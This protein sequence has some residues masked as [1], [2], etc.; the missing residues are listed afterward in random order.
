MRDI[1]LFSNDI[2]VF[3]GLKA[4]VAREK[5]LNISGWAKNISELSSKYEI[6]MPDI[7]LVDSQA[8][9]GKVCSVLSDLKKRG[10][11]IILLLGRSAQM[12]YDWQDG[13]IPISDS[14]SV[15]VEELR[16]SARRCMENEGNG[17]EEEIS[18]PKRERLILSLL[19]DGETVA[20]IASKLFISDHTVKKHI[21][22]IYRKLNVR[23]R[24]Q[25][26]RK[27]LSMKL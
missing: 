20:S 14:P 13:C 19:A 18:L 23:N 9:D 4:M 24:G 8:I 10:I 25:A 1:L 2:L 5:D 11:S 6:H 21:S 3:E 26:I 17:M 12:D 27:A 16:F 7:I 22:N 15:F